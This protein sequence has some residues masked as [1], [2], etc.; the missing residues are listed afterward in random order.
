[1]DVFLQV[2]TLAPNFEAVIK[3]TFS[4]GLISDAY[5]IVGSC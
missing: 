2:V 4:S 5:H 3:P 1:M